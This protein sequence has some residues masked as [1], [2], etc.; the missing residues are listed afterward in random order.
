M[1]ESGRTLIIMSG[2]LLSMAALKAVISFRIISGMDW[3]ALTSQHSRIVRSKL[4]RES[5]SLNTSLT[6]IVAKEPLAGSFSSRLLMNYL[7]RAPRNSIFSQQDRASSTTRVASASAAGGR[8]AT[9]S[10]VFFKQINGEVGTKLRAIGQG[11]P[12]EVSTED[13]GLPVRLLKC[14]DKFSLAGGGGLGA[15]AGGRVCRRAVAAGPLP[16]GVEV[17]AVDSGISPFS[18]TPS[19]TLIRA[20]SM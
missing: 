8:P 6:G 2:Y 15:A 5:L 14:L 7:E 19:T 9:F 3:T 12:A 10:S 1:A 13:Y 4:R 18:T 17:G 11:E 20:T 16:P